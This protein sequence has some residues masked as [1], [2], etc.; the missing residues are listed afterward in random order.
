M[1]IKI[2]YPSAIDMVRLLNT[3]IVDAARKN[4]IS[5]ILMPTLYQRAYMLTYETGELPVVSGME[6]PDVRATTGL[7]AGSF[8]TSNT[9]R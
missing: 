1:E 2:L 7:N 3:S 9:L 5:F 4:T 8:N 6:A